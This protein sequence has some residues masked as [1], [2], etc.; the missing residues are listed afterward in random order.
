MGAKGKFDPATD[1]YPRYAVRAS[2]TTAKGVVGESALSPA[3][4]LPTPGD[5]K[6]AGIKIHPDPETA[7]RL[8][9][10]VRPSPGSAYAGS[11]IIDEEAGTVQVTCTGGATVT[12]KSD[13]SL[14]LQAGGASVGLAGGNITLTPAAGGKVKINGAWE[15]PVP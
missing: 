15:H 13:N 5:D 12:L 9:L 6:L 2:F 14:L 1:G 4:Q 7:K 3:V 10:Y 8:E 11:V